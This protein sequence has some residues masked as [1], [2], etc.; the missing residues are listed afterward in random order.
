M[1]AL[2]ELYPL[3]HLILA[4]IEVIL[5]IFAYPFFRISRNLAMITLPFILFSTIYDN[6]IL[7]SGRFIGEGNLLENL[8]QGRYFLHYAFVPLLIVVAIELAFAS[9]AKWANQIVRVLSWLLAFG[10]AGYDL[11]TRFIGLELTPETFAGVLRYVPLI[12]PDTPITQIIPISTILI[13]VFVCLIGIGI[14][15]RANNWSWLFVGSII[16]LIGNALPSAKYGPLL[17]SAAECFLVLG[18]LLTQYHFED[19]LEPD[20]PATIEPPPGW[21]KT[22][23]SGYQIFWKE[24]NQQS[25][26][27][28]TIYQTG[29]HRDGDFVRIY[30][31]KNPYQENG[32][33]KVITYLHGFSLCLPKF[34]EDHLKRLV[35]EGYYVFFPDFQQS[36][37][38]DFTKS[39]YSD[40]TKVDEQETLQEYEKEIKPLSYWLRNFGVFLIKFIFRTEIKQKKFTRMAKVNEK[41]ERLKGLQESSRSLL[42]VVIIYVLYLFNQKVGKNLVNMI[43]TVVASLTQEPPEWLGF[44]V[45]T[46]VIGWEKLCEHSKQELDLLDLSQKDIDF[47]VFG[48]SLGGLLALSWPYGLNCLEKHSEDK[49]PKIKPKQIIAKEKYS[50][51][52]PKQIITG[53]PAPNTAGGIPPLVFKIIKFLGFPFAVNELD[54]QETG[55]DL[56]KIPVIPV[57][58]L[59]GNDDQIVLPKEWVEPDPHTQKSSFCAI[60][61][62]QKKIYFSLSNQANDLTAN[63]NQSVTNSTYYGDAFM[64][65]FGGAKKAPN[66]YNFGYIWSALDAVVKSE[67]QAD[68]LKDQHGFCLQDF[69]V[70]EDEPIYEEEQ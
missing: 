45:N 21:N 31:P 4:L 43:S 17:G 1:N 51:F 49:C 61:S 12:T 13:N 68:Q 9:G 57:G 37:Y 5:L 56:A 3:G 63:H 22:E 24:E 70:V 34:Y 29:S 41:G 15:V 54:I 60:K 33:F 23:Y 67:V 2:L 14:W 10:I 55:K 39:D 44:A 38:P 7:F 64:D 46:T 32:R 8:S 65:N 52:H 18:L 11:V 28:Y 35:Q 66:A 50:K 53:D 59:H 69:K 26:S 42:L 19:E 20:E 58:I 30:A 27:A 62:T 40:L 25:D 16:A 6:V 47:Y 36:D 48:H